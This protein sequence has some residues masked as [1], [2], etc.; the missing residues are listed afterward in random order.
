[1]SI[2]AMVTWFER[3]LPWR[4]RWQSVV[5]GCTVGLLRIAE[6][7]SSRHGFNRRE[8][9]RPFRLRT[10]ISMARSMWAARYLTNWRDA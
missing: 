5:L 3:R 9:G 1:M 8:N 4:R 2:D 10:R 6:W 7:S